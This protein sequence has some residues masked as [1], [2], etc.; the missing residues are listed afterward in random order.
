MYAAVSGLKTHM[1]AL[2]VIGHNIANVNTNAYKAKRY[3]F[4]EALYTDVHAGSN[5]T[6]VLGGRNPAQIGYGVSVATVDIDMST[7]N[8]MPTGNQ[9]DCLIDGDGFLIVGDKIPNPEHPAGNVET[10]EELQGM[11]LTRHGDLTFVNGFLVDGQ[12]KVVYGYLNRDV[13]VPGAGADEENVTD[14]QTIPALTAIHLPMV[15]NDEN[16]EKV[17]VFPN[18]T[19]YEPGSGGAGI[20]GWIDSNGNEIE[21]EAA[22]EA[23]NPQYVVLQNLSIEESGRIV[24]SSSDRQ[25]VVG[26]V[27]LAQVDN[28]NG[29]SHV[30]GRYY[31]AL[32]G[33]GNIHL[34]S[35]AGNDEIIGLD[36]PLEIESA[37]TK[38]LNG[39][40]EMSGTDLATEIANMITIQRGYQANTRI[41]T[42][43]DSMLEELINMKR[44]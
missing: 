4:A 9:L 34:C 3:T 41:V 33:A 15:Y 23:L 16:G 7:K 5:G 6:D 35:V 25:F 37:K 19:E 39:G 42:V 21:D 18:S 40:L 43:T 31:E 17:Y 10:M 29:V 27:A 1:N 2:N 13:V 28:P 38:F 30:D 12:G 14:T 32:G 22:L 20:E 44:G 36:G 8:Y 11:E 24:G 26:Y